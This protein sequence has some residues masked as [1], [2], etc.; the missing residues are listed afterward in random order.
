MA[1]PGEVPSEISP[2]S[3]RILQLGQAL[4]TVLGLVAFMCQS[5]ML[6]GSLV[7]NTASLWRDLLGGKRPDSRSST[8][9]EQI[10]KVPRKI[11]LG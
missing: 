3:V 1:D 9:L 6:P 11:L 10:W 4:G 8:V 7:S 5:V 2:S